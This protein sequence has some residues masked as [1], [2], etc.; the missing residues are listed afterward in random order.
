MSYPAETA[1]RPPAYPVYPGPADGRPP[2][3]PLTKRMR[4]GHWIAL[5]CAVGVFAA[6]CEVAVGAGQHFPYG[7]RFPFVVLFVAAVFLPVALRRRA[8][9]TAFGALVVLA[10]LLDLFDGLN[11]PAAA[12]IF[13]AAA[14]VLYTVT[15]EGRRRS[16][17]AALALALLVMLVLGAAAG[18]QAGPEHADGGVFV[19]VALACII[20]WITGYT[21]RQRRRYVVT[22]QHQAVSRA[23]AEE[24]LR[25]ARE[26]HDVV[27][28][29]MSVIAVQAGY[30]QYVIDASPGRARDALGAIQ[31]TSRDALEE[32]RRMLG[33]LRQQDA[34]PSPAEAH[35][36]GAGGTA[37]ED[38]DSARRADPAASPGLAPEGAGH[39][40]AGRAP[41]A[42]APGLAGLDRLITR[43]R[44]AG[45]E[46]TLEVAG[47]VRPAPAGVD[48]SAYRIIQ[49]ALTNVV[50]HAGTGASCIV[51][52]TYTQLEL[53][54]QV[55]DDGGR[56]SSGRAA[57]LR[58]V[59]A[60]LAG[61]GTAGAGLSGAGLSGAGLAGTGLAG[62]GL[63]GSGAAGT[64]SAGT[65][66]EG[67]AAAGAGH[68]IIG[69]QERVNLCGGSF[70]AGT[71]PEGGFQVIAALPLPPGRLPTG[72]SPAPGPQAAARANSAVPL[73]SS[74]V[75]AGNAA[76]APAGSAA[77]ASPAGPSASPVPVAR[78]AGGR[79]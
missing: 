34:G 29:S 56:P 25:I 66:L 12:A 70:R 24:R 71:L 2:R 59:P 31:A 62:S 7:F 13:L 46:L 76:V 65:G 28:H 68:G 3:P 5:D 77:F 22:L 55:T 17:A 45:V 1:H 40:A 64:V 75:P 26:L 23:V 50:R 41:L 30:G 9:A 67:L 35:P 10:V 15:V 73:A 43:T 61:S 60:G 36:A 44:G 63:A 53:V 69:M 74:A 32:M 78:H 16:G 39:P 57:D 11:P 4:P 49:E 27:A 47:Q 14:Y 42:P 18:Y 58:A 72:P 8:P 37:L 51:S 21:V 54:I 6:L 79:R 52:V 33:V 19:P 38:P 48:L 20:A